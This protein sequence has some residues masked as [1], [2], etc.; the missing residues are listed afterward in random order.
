MV[1][2]GVE[3]KLRKLRR[4]KESVQVIAPS[5]KVETTLT[6]RPRDFIVFGRVIWRAGVL[7]SA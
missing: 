6:G 7:K 1:A 5:G 3:L 2:S 4:H